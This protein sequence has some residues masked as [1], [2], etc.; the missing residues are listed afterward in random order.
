M[1]P[2]PSVSLFFFRESINTLP[3][4]LNIEKW[5]ATDY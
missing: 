1:T 3:R 2:I 4:N 5:L